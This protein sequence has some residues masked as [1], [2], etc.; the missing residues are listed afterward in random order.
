MPC[1]FVSAGW[2]VNAPAEA[3]ISYISDFKRW[4]AWSPFET[5]DPHMKREYSGASQGVG[6]VYGWNGSGKAGEGTMEI[7]EAHA[8]Q[9]LAIALRFVR[10]VP[11]E[12]VATFSL[13]PKD[14]G[15]AVSWSMHGPNLWIAQVMQV[16]CNMDALIGR[17][18]EAGL[19]KLK[20]AAEDR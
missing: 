15:T 8:P 7:T 20:V 11:G 1:H 19:T 18:F 4:S 14:G 17:D 5:I 2:R 6:A 9:H 10:P 12:N 3:I 13:V 16:F